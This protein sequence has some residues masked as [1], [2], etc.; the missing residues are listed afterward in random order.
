[1]TAP[2]P[3]RVAVVGCGYFARFHV[4]GWTRIPGVTVVAL[5][6]LDATKRETMA[7]DFGVARTFASANDMLAEAPCD[8][9]DIAT[10]PPTHT[11]LIKLGLSKGLTVVCQK[12]FCT[13]YEEAVATTAL[14][15]ADPDKLIVHENFRF[16]P[17][18]REIKRHLDAGVLGDIYQVTFRMRPG[19]GQGPHAYLARQPY[20][21]KM[22][23]FLVRETAIHF[24]D[25]FRYLFGEI[26]G[27]SADL[28]RLNPAI[29]GEDAAILN[30]TFESGVRGLFDANRLSDHPADDRR[31]TM[32]EMLI[33]GS[34]GTIRLDG[35]GRLFIRKF[36]E[37]A[38]SELLYTWLD[39]GYGG[40]CVYQ[41]ILHVI[42]HLRDGQPL[43]TKAQ[44]YLCNNL[45]EEAV[46]SS[47]LRKTYVMIK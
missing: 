4:D 2:R 38:E 45:I 6:D 29:V 47:H 12:P 16:E 14:A 27:V 44:S 13:S 36:G 28:R 5:A 7:R 40:D 30:F 32:G 3:L 19:D 35:F 1:M 39:R 42:A 34:L 41:F 18:Y 33:E 9:L 43:E 25:T 15:D 37:N 20:F 11:T 21:Q 8:I 10:P 24:I 46:Y 31:K 26:E 22:P 17:W 23:R